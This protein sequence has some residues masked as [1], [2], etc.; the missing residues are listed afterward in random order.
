MRLKYFLKKMKYNPKR[1]FMFMFLFL[2][3]VS[4]TVGYAFLTTTMN[5]D[6][7][8]KMLEA[9][10]DIHFENIQVQGGSVTP[11]T[12][13]TIV[14]PTSITFGVTL[15]NPGDFY[16][17]HVDVVNDGTLD[18]MIESYSFLPVLTSE[19]EEYL[20][21][22]VAYSDDSPI[23]IYQR[24]NAGTQEALKVR[25]GYKDGID[26]SLYPLQD[27]ELTI[28]V[29]IVY[30]QVNEN[31]IDVA[32]V[33]SLYNILA[34]SSVMDNINSTYVQNGTPGVDF[35][36]SS[37]DTNGK[38]IYTR[39][40]TENDTYPV[41]YFRGN[42]TN[43]NV[44]FAGICWKIVRTTDTGGIKLIYNGEPNGGS[45]NISNTEGIGTSKWSDSLRDLYHVGYMQGKQYTYIQGGSGYRYDYIGP[46]VIYEN[47]QYTLVGNSNYIVERVNLIS[48]NTAYR[49]YDCI[50]STSCEKVLYVFYMNGSQANY[51]ELSNGEKIEDAL[52]NMLSNISDSIIKT[53]VDS[54]YVNNINSYTNYLED[55]VWCFDRELNLTSVY[56]SNS[57]PGFNPVGGTAYLTYFQSHNRVKV[58][59]SPSL[60]CSRLV[61][62]FTVNSSNGNG[63]LTYPIGLLTVDELLLAGVG[64]DS[65]YLKF[66]KIFWTAN[67]MNYNAH[68][69]ELDAYTSNLD[70]LSF[71]FNTSYPVRPAISLQH[72]SVCSDG[73]GTAENPYVIYTN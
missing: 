69:R 22:Q 57:M 63:A 64:S 38:G 28:E 37:S 66:S 32:H 33:F 21:Y 9:R 56:N 19:Q 34:T 60:Q 20:E 11:T 59:F 48:S 15:E 73:D 14:T 6:G 24:L 39:S 47:N 70:T 8:S 29:E 30:V 23:A 61:D 31:A 72:N 35:S 16:E 18:A 12:D 54:W 17:F 58:L 43:N 45:C 10:W 65:N 7:V 52:N 67:F 55:T 62:S 25:F 50:T 53:F 2:S 71:D 4:L 41:H 40:G 13:A 42:V 44:L 5:I 27:Q 68:Y 46:D 1:S 51:F 36:Q 26:P 3:L 49:H